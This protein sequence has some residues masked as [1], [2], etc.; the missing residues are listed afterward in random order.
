MLRPGLIALLVAELLYL[1]IRFDSQALDDA[2]S[3]WLRVVAWS[4]QYLRLAITITVV[5]LLLQVR[6]L[7]TDDAPEAASSV[8][9]PAC[10]PPS[11]RFACLGVHLVALLL[12]IQVSESVFDSSA[13]TFGVPG[14][15]AYPGLWVGAWL[16]LGALAITA[17][18]LAF[19]PRHITFLSARRGRAVAG[20]GIVLGSAAWLSGVL[21]EALWAPLARHTFALAGGM[22]AIIYPQI[23]SDPDRLILGTPSFKV[24]IAPQCSGYEG[25]GLLLAFLTA[26]LCLFRRELRFPGALALLPLGA[27][28]IWVVNVVRIVLLIVIGTSGWPTI[29]LGGF[30]SQAGWLAFNAVALAFVALLNR[31]RFFMRAAPALASAPHVEGD[32]TTAYLAPF[33]VVMASAMVTG[34]FSAGIDWLYPLRVVA[35]VWV[36][37][38]F[39]KSYS[40]LGWTLS[41]RAVAIGCVT[42]AIWIALVPADRVNAGWPSALQSVPFHWAA[43]WM[44]L[45]VIGYTITVPLVEE[46]AFRGYLT[47]RLMRAD[48]QRLPV[49]LFSW[50]SFLVSSALFGALHGGLWLAGTIA[51]MTF[52][53]ALYQRRAFGDAV[54]AHATTNGLIALYVLATGRWSVWS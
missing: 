13:V 16:L 7:R 42:F 48:F 47:R 5:T 39:R 45:R 1:T 9:S 6:R 8:R 11:A 18:A 46:L 50:S 17:W 53:L 28:T 44:L 25:V 20:L 2:P 54:L 15:G 31:G 51:G 49:G 43:A 26:Y 14:A 22:L 37:W 12:F 27:V 19:A 10:V 36:L 23:V 40:N 29:A 38:V 35:A 24:A 32:S 21:T 3:A 4:P 52:A 30:H 33:V 34:A 41:W